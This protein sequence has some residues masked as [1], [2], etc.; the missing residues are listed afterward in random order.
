MSYL[1]LFSTCAIGRSIPAQ[2]FLPQANVLACY[3]VEMFLFAEHVQYR[4]IFS[5]VL[6]SSI[7]CCV[8]TYAL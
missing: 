3:C 7:G 1:L 8:Q 4:H 6:I 5:H 2:S